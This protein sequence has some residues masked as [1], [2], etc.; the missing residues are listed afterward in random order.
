MVDLRE[1]NQQ[2]NEISKCWAESIKHIKN[3]IGER[4]ELLSLKDKKV[5]YSKS[6]THNDILVLQDL[7]KQECADFS[8]HVYALFF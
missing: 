5:K 7:V 1:K 4:F 2:N 6:E 3:D 8:V